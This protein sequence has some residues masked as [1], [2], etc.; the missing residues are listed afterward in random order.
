MTEEEIR[1]IVKEEISEFF[2]QVETE[3][4]SPSSMEGGTDT[5]RSLLR[6][7]F[8]VARDRY[9]QRGRT[10]LKRSGTSKRSISKGAMERW[11]DDGGATQQAALVVGE[12]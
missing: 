3:A 8:I 12:P 7:L 6:R 10:P 2:H 4:G 9:D 1:V 11:A 5:A